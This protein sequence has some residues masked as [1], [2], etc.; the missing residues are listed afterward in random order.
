V[1]KKKMFTLKPEIYL[2]EHRKKIF[3][4]IT[5][6]IIILSVYSNTFHASWHFDDIP[7]IIDNPDL[8]LKE[9]SWQNIK[10]TFYAN[11]FERGYL[12][13]PVACLSFAVNYYFSK[14]NVLGY[15]IVNISIHFLAAFFLFLFIYHSLNLQS[16]QSKYNTNSYF[17]ALLSTLLW[18]IN[19]IQTQ[20]ITYIVQRMA[21][22]A[23][24]FYIISMYLYLKGK[25]S[26]K[27]PAKIIFFILCIVSAMLALG[28]KEN[29]ILIPLSLFLYDFLLFQGI[30]REKR[31]KQIK[32]LVVTIIITLIICVIYFSFSD[33]TVFS[34]FKLYEKRVFTLWERLLT[35]SRVIIFYI[36]LILYPVST[37]LS[38]GHDMDISQSFFDPPTT[39]LCIMLICGI[40]I[41]SLYISK[42][43][44]L[45]EFSVLFFFL[46]HIVESSILPLEMIFE[47]RN[48]IPT[49]LFF[50]PIAI[51][52][53]SAISYFSSKR[54]MQAIITIS[55]ILVIIGHSHATFMRNFTWKNE[56]SLWID[57][58]D[59][60]PEL[61][62]CSH[63]LSKCYEDH[64][65][66]EKAIIEYNKTLDL[67]SINRTDEK[68][69]TYFNLGAIYLMR[70]EFQKSKEYFARAI[71]IDPCCPGTHNNLAIALAATTKNYQ[72]VYSELQR[73]LTCNPASMRAQSNLGILL[74]KAGKITEGV[75][76]IKKA[77]EIEPDN[78]PT[79]L[80][81]GY[82]YM[83][84]GY[85][86]RASIYFKKV[87]SKR[88]SNNLAFLFLAEIY[89]RSGHEQKAMKSV[90]QFLDAV[91]DNNLIP[92]LKNHF[93]EKSLLTIT[94]TMDIV[95]P[96]L[97]KAYK[98]REELLAKN[99]NFL[100]D[101][102]TKQ[103]KR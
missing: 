103:G 95:V 92:F 20:A 80:R 42:R 68:A 76:E 50:V 45:I 59:K 33:T 75:A 69:M 72:E 30:S 67:T 58:V 27:N 56:E 13:R 34:F 77:L 82:A 63:N 90:S 22:M 40:I 5:L 2:S 49:M 79:L 83:K 52:L 66:I 31:K 88:N 98:D 60:Y 32:Y 101:K 36:T 18:A 85:L 39:I 38:I 24:M 35:Q 55:I 94:P 61:Y 71:E 43:R 29:A 51:G 57:C 6:F 44:P 8:H 84:E 16:I 1:L 74:V 41:S 54:S 64:N 26:S 62:R 19:P 14:N 70:K 48:Y 25:T 15:H 91:Q 21:S 17:I 47:H 97:Y 78:V 28:S 23:G 99:R 93:E 53:I 89:A 65:Q 100:S 37:R 11:P 46:N 10:K 4:F 7:N 102:H 12:Y 87:I 9:F 96:L 86:G 73:A 3:A 81:L